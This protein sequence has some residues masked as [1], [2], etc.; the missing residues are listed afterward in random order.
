MRT[1][2]V[3]LWQRNSHGACHDVTQTHPGSCP[4]QS[5]KQHRI[6][7]VGGSIFQMQKC[8]TG[9]LTLQKLQIALQTLEAHFMHSEHD[10]NWRLCVQDLEI[11]LQFSRSTDVKSYWNG[12][13]TST[14]QTRRQ[15]AAVISRTCGHHG[16]VHG[17]IML[18]IGPTSFVLWQSE[19]LSIMNVVVKPVLKFNRHL[20]WVVGSCASRGG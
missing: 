2:F 14:S 17:Q 19:S 16:G 8:K 5:G 13:T 10:V 7:V 6:T 15:S 18:P 9:K 12:G 20:L 3:C 4:R 1:S 11:A